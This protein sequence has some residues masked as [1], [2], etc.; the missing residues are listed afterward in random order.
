MAKC[1][2][3]N[4]PDFNRLVESSGLHPVILSAKMGVWMEKN[5][6]DNWPTL[7]QLDLVKSIS[8]EPS[9]IDLFKDFLITATDITVSDIEKRI[10][11]L[12]ENL[13]SESTIEEFDKLLA[14]Q[15]RTQR[16]LIALAEKLRLVPSAVKHGDIKAAKV[17][18]TSNDKPIWED[19]D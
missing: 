16:V 13:D 6:T 15:A 3:I 12:I 1:V 10:A 4:H 5:N 19:H 9:S 2:N 18:R 17:L 7:E 11:G 14:M 8:R